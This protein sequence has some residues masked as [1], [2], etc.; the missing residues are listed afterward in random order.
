MERLTNFPGQL[1]ACG[2]GKQPKLLNRLG[3]NTF[4]CECPPCGVRTPFFK[5]A[6][7]A[8]ASWEDS[9][10]REDIR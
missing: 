5:S 10:K 1:T 4:A 2:C 3:P 7:E 8:V 6:Q 9:T